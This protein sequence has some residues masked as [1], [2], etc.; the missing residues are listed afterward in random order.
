MEIAILDALTL[1][2]DIDLNRFEHFGKLSVYQTT[3]PEELPERLANAEIV[4]SNKVYLGKAEIE[5]APN[6]KLI[7]VAATGYNNIDI[8]WASKKG[9]VVANVRN[10]STEGVAQHTFSLI[11]A[12]ENSLI[13]YVND[14]RAGLWASSPVFTMLSYPFNELKGR[15]LGIIG[16]GNIGKRVAE[17]AHVFGMQVLIGKRRGINYE[18]H[19]RVDFDVLL[20]ES[21]IISIHTPLS[22]NTRNLF[23]I[24]EFERMKS[25]ATLINVARGGIVN[26]NDLYKALI[27]KI[28]RAAAID[29]SETE[30]MD[31]QNKLSSLTN[32]LVSP[33]IAWAS[34]QSRVRLIEG[35]EHNIEKFLDGRGSEINLAI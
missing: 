27:N 35:I 22:E 23:T 29:V 24:K 34:S 2:N 30:P 10:Y 19:D 11:L 12:L 32:L 25:S 20:K 18:G 14:T 8:S 21:D 17:I 33:H 3:K 16:C 6:L 7:C 31:S 28:I 1:G 9:I 4:I 13:N 5:K 15:K 26:E